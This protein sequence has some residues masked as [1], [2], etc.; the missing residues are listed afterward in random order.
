[1]PTVPTLLSLAVIVGILAIVTATSL[2]ATRGR[3]LVS[4][5][6]PGEPAR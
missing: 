5:A 3:A 1:V 4:D 6:A 2:L